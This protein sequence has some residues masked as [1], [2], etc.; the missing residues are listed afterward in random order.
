MEL[1]IN[2]IGQ[3]KWVILHSGTLVPP[4]SLSV[5]RGR[6]TDPRPSTG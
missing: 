4:Y 1:D 5:V 2:Q 6:V 3:T